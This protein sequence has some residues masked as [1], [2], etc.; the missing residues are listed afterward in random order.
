[1]T[2]DE[3]VQLLQQHAAELM[4]ESGAAALS[5]FGSVARDECGPDSDVDVLVD[6]PAPPSFYQYMRLKMRLADLLGCRVDLVTRRALRSGTRPFIE[7]EA[8]RVA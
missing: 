5:V 3:V 1:M 2:R 8:L 6:F 7:A 4:A